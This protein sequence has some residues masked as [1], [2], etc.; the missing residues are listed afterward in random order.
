[1]TRPIPEFWDPY[2]FGMTGIMGAG[3]A[4]AL[5]GFWGWLFLFTAMAAHSVYKIGHLTAAK[6]QP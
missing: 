2:I 1:M 6:H 3:A 4:Y 5:A